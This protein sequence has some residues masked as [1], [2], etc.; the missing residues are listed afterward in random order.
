VNVPFN[1]SWNG[2]GN[3][4]PMWTQARAFRLNAI[5]ASPGDD[6]TFDWQSGAPVVA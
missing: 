4:S 5:T 1:G 3:H 6:V 2:R